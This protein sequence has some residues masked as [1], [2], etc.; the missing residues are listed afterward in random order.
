MENTNEIILNAKNLINHNYLSIKSAVAI[1][2]TN[3]LEIKTR[4]FFYKGEL[5]I[6]E[7]DETIEYKNYKMP[8]DFKYDTSVGNDKHTNEIIF[9]LKKQICGFLNRK[10]GR[11]YIGINDSKIVIGNH[12]NS[13]DRDKTR[14]E[15]TNL[16]S[17]FFPKCRTEKIR[18][19]YVPVRNKLT[20][21][22]IN[23]LYIIKIIIKQGEVNRL[24]STTSRGFRSF[25]RLP[26]QCVELSAE[27]IEK[28]LVTRMSG[29]NS[30]K[31][32][33]PEEFE[34]ND[35]ILTLTSDSEDPIIQNNNLTNL[36]VIGN[37]DIGLKRNLNIPN[38]VDS[39]KVVDLTKDNS[40][41]AFPKDLKL[42]YPIQYAQ[43]NRTNPQNLSKKINGIESPDINYKE[44]LMKIKRSEYSPNF[45]KS[46]SETFPIKISISNLRCDATKDN[47]VDLL[48]DFNFDS[49]VPI[50]I[51]RFNNYDYS[52]AFV[53][54]LSKIEAI[55][56][57]QSLD[58]AE[59]NNRIL[60]VKIL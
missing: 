6:A 55:Q 32:V 5:L 23:N 33:D 44:K 7:E 12:L 24:Y 8:L 28:N 16:T 25:M 21:R 42:V 39:D 36:R 26:G 46:F 48:K 53:H 11:I 3:S 19:V 34:D 17:D 60:Q 41:T 58:G 4:N 57:K 50:I 56:V 10:G 1:S 51:K 15:L 47:I 9:Q 29:E 20:D 27:E 13:K 43:S 31:K 22:H 38:P 37:L 52:C 49:S 14:N 45:K 18:V 54:F 30:F 35:P 59:L 2:D 40:D